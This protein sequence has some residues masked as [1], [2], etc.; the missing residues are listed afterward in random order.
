MRVGPGVATLRVIDPATP[1]ASSVLV[2][3]R[4]EVDVHAARQA[5]LRCA[6]ALGFASAAGQEVAIVASEL[7]WNVLTHGGGGSLEVVAVEDARRGV[8]VELRAD[9]EGAPIADLALAVRDGHSDTGRLTAAELIG[10]R[11]IGSGLG[12]VVR[13]SDE[14]RYE[15]RERGKRVVAVRYR[16]RPGRR[17]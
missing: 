10:R 1:S 6:R 13:L 12:A 5:A 17:G 16:T 2:P 4:D 7:A 8:G 3:V 14:F 9:D 15:G 11:G